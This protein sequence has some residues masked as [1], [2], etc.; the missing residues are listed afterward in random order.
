MGSGTSGKMRALVFVLVT[1]LFSCARGQTDDDWAFDAPLPDAQPA[2]VPAVPRTT[3]TPPGVPGSSSMPNMPSA[4]T[5]MGETGPITSPGAQLSIQSNPGSRDSQTLTQDSSQ[6]VEDSPVISGLAPALGHIRGLGEQL[7]LS[8][9][10]GKEAPAPYICQAEKEFRTRRKASTGLMLEVFL[11]P[12]GGA[13]FYYGDTLGGVLRTMLM[14]ISV[15]GCCV[16]C[17]CGAREDYDA[18]APMDHFDSEFGQKRKGLDSGL[19]LSLGLMAAWV[20][21]LGWWAIAIVRVGAMASRPSLENSCLI[22]L[23]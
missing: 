13:N 1:T 22:P 21:M 10:G 3:L 20:V 18:I 8:E 23:S 12:T 16:Q 9:Q 6:L 2:L 17:C 5:V 14:L 7:A 11:G 19:S 4:T 15:M